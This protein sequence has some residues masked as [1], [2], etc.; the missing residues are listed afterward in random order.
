MYTA[1]DFSQQQILQRCKLNVPTVMAHQISSLGTYLLDSWMNLPLMSPPGHHVAPLHINSH[2]RGL[3][4][5]YDSQD[6]FLLTARGNPY[7]NVVRVGDE[8]VVHTAE[9][10]DL[11][12]KPLKKLVEEKAIS[13]R[14]FGCHAGCVETS[15]SY[16]VLH[17]PCKLGSTVLWL[18]CES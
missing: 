13:Q 2:T 14:G 18:P 9:G 1:T 6:G 8:V 10:K 11:R 17:L 5:K 7:E 12:L 16:G 3:V 4:Q 15:E